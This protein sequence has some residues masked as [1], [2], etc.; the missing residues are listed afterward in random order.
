[1]KPQKMSKIHNNRLKKKRKNLVGDRREK[2]E[3]TFYRSVILDLTQ[4]SEIK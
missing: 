3:W 2:V 1:M 4:K